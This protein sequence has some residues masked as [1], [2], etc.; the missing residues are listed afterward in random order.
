MK[1][2]LSIGL[3]EKMMTTRKAV[4]LLYAPITTQLIDQEGNNLLTQLAGTKYLKATVI[5]D[6][7]EF[8]INDMALNG[9]PMEKSIFDH[10]AYEVQKWGGDN[11][12]HFT[13][14]AAKQLDKKSDVI[15]NARE[16]FPERSEFRRR[17]A[18][19]HG[20]SNQKTSQAFGGIKKIELKSKK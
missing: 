8:V 14:N 16:N 2:D 1:E 13:G 5:L 4:S 15:M 18:G 17:D 20:G 12:Q 11:K 3:V 10:A 9:W 7:Y 19:M 6:A